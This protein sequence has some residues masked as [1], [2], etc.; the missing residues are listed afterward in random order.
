MNYEKMFKDLENTIKKEIDEYCENYKKYEDQG[1]KDYAHGAFHALSTIDLYIQTMYE[2]NP[3]GDENFE[4]FARRM[5]HKNKFK[6]TESEHYKPLGCFICPAHVVLICPL[7]KL[8][9]VRKNFEGQLDENPI[10]G[11]QLKMFL[12]P[13]FGNYEVRSLGRGAFIINNV[14][15]AIVA[16]RIS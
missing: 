15:G 5:K 1:E 9:R 11:P 2:E 14:A 10:W 7:D 4:R 13:Y 16:P 12:I 3:K 8:D 6:P